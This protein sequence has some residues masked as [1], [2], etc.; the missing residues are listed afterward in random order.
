MAKRK[1]PNAEFFRKH[2]GVIPNVRRYEYTDGAGKIL[3]S[4]ERN[5]DGILV[6]TTERDKLY[7]EIADATEAIEKMREKGVNDGQSIQN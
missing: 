1:D 3:E 2:P 4:W 7:Q 6:E 5:K